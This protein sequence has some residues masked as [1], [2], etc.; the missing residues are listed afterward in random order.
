MLEILWNVFAVV[1]IL[2]L[3]VN[4]VTKFIYRN[5]DLYNFMTLFGHERSIYIVK[6]WFEFVVLVLYVAYL[7]YI[8]KQ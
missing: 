5:S 8:F 4:A 3:I 2:D 7:I 6:R 1:C